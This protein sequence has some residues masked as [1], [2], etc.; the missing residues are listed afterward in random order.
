LDELAKSYNVGVSTIRRVTPLLDRRQTAAMP[1]SRGR[2]PK[3]VAQRGKPK[4]VINRPISHHRTTQKMI[5][6]ANSS[7]AKGRVERAHKTL[8]DR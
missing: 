3:K 4:S 5:I 6:C 7:Q 2:K 8:Q 1:K